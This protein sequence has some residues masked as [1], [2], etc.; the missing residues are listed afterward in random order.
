VYNI[1]T[2]N[3][4]AFQYHYKSKPAETFDTKVIRIR[5][6]RILVIFVI[7]SLT[8]FFFDDT[9]AQQAPQDQIQPSA[10]LGISNRSLD[11]VANTANLNQDNEVMM[12]SFGDDRI[13]GSNGS[14][15]IIGLLGS[16]TLRGRGGD[17][18]LQGNEDVDRLYGEIGNDL[19]QGGMASDQLY[20]GEGED[21]LA[22][23]I[24][25]DF[26]IGEQGN[27]KLY[28]GV[29]DD[30]LQGSEGADYFDCGD[31]VDIVI[32]FNIEEGDDNAG[33][34]EEITSNDNTNDN[35]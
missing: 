23:G 14:D 28:G 22:G 27:D 21:I 17:D 9:I 10:T 15:I 6:S 34:C 26:L 1:K 35:P 31:G 5:S 7:I 30:I 12:G 2:D 3:I 11:S 4:I 29:D 25:D 13:T 18:K 33:N 16:D 20:G 8:I 32:D 24:G 19:L